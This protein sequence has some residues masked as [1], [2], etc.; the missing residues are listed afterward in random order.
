[1]QRF[2][3]SKLHLLFAD[4][5]LS[6]LPREDDSDAN[7]LSRGV[8]AGVVVLGSPTPSLIVIGVPQGRHFMRRA[9]F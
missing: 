2:Q 9:D 5:G 8:I 3:D 7:K 4:G 1:M 6:R